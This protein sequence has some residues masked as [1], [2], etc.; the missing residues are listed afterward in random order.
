MSKLKSPCQSCGSAGRFFV[1]EKASVE[2]TAEY[3]IPYQ[4]LNDF[5]I[6]SKR[7]TLMQTELNSEPK[8]EIDA[9]RPLWLRVSL[10]L[11]C[12]LLGGGLLW[13]FARWN[14]SPNYAA[15]GFMMGMTFGLIYGERL[16]LVIL[17]AW[18]EWRIP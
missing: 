11:I 8:T 7:D 5:R 3:R 14:G 16:F 15:L 1:C 2:G 9:D 12:G 10:R 17:G 18:S 6:R 13:I 4:N